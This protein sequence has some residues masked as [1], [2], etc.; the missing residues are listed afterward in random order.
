MATEEK[1]IVDMIREI[2]VSVE[3][4]TLPLESFPLEDLIKLI[5]TTLGGTFWQKRGGAHQTAFGMLPES[6]RKLLQHCIKQKDCEACTRILELLELQY[7][8]LYT[9]LSVEEK[10]KYAEK[11]K[12]LA[13][14][15]GNAYSTLQYWKH[16]KRRK[17]C[18][19]ETTADATE[20]EARTVISG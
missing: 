19:E 2:R 6:Y 8:C 15:M 18:T 16:E 10:E 13:I 9:A 12:V 14:L 7:K 5:D 20:E 11:Y 1:Q 3:N 4:K 17:T